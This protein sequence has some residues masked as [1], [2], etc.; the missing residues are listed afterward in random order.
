M[1]KQWP[2][3]ILLFRGEVIPTCQICDRVSETRD[4]LDFWS[5]TNFWK[6][7]EKKQIQQSRF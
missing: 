1:E 3:H 5:P 2:K 7:Q 4:V 6:I